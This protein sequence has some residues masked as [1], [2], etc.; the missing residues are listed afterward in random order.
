MR[1]RDCTSSPDEEPKG[2][3]DRQIRDLSYE[4]FRLQNTGWGNSVRF[5][6]TKAKLDELVKKRENMQKGYISTGSVS[7]SN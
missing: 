5:K 6:E 7:S 2:P 1:R 4:L 3:L